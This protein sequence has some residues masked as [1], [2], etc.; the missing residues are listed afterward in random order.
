MMTI[1]YERQTAVR[2]LRRRALEDM[3]IA[4]ALH[5]VDLALQ[6]QDSELIDGAY[7]ALERLAPAYTLADGKVDFDT[8]SFPADRTRWPLVLVY[9]RVDAVIVARSLPKVRVRA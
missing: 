7:L 3:R 2:D 5:D 6:R 8:D 9:S 4:R 1:R